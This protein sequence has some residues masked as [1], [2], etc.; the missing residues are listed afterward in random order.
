MVGAD[1]EL[2]RPYIFVLFPQVVAEVN[3]HIASKG[4]YEL[5]LET[6]H[7]M[8]LVHHLAKHDQLQELVQRTI[9]ADRYN[10]SQAYIYNGGLLKWNL[11]IV[12]RNRLKYK[13]TTIPL[14]RI[15]CN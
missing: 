13:F 10:K 11:G 15:Y 12:S 4:M 3:R 9:Q 1:P 5:L 8:G 7:F 14:K 2:N 6:K